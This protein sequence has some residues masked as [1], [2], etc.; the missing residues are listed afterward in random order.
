ML[1]NLSEDG[2]LIRFDSV[3]KY[4]KQLKPFWVL[5]KVTVFR[6]DNNIYPIL[7][8]KVCDKMKT[9][10]CLKLSQSQ[11]QLKA[12]QCLHSIV[13]ANL[14]NRGGNW[15]QRWG[16]QN[17]DIDDEDNAYVLRFGMNH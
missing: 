5:L 13:G 6:E 14:I 4:K 17:D 12:H 1:R 2:D 11:N 8:C 15:Q 10:H 9:L 7:L 3:R 16:I